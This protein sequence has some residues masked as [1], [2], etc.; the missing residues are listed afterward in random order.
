MTIRKT[1]N[2]ILAEFLVLFK[3]IGSYHFLC[4]CFSQ[5]C[6]FHSHASPQK[7]LW[8]LQS[9]EFAD[10][11]HPNVAPFPALFEQVIAYPTV[12]LA[13]VKSLAPPYRSIPEDYHVTVSGF[14]VD[15]G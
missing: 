14:I 7:S 6:S 5:T 8:R 9:S 11:D 3:F 1:I 2:L 13:P 10:I 15:F 4:E 12:F